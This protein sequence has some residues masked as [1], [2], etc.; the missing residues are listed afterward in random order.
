MVKRKTYAGHCVVCVFALL[1]TPSASW[2]LLPVCPLLSRAVHRPE[3]FRGYEIHQQTPCF[4]HRSS[5]GRWINACHLRATTRDSDAGLTDDKDCLGD[6]INTQDRTQE[7]SFLEWAGLR[8]ISAP[9]VQI[10]EFPAG[11]RGMAATTPIAAGEALV[12]LP[13][14]ICLSVGN[15]QPCPFPNFVSAAFW[16][17]QSLH[18]RLALVL[19][20]EKYQRLSVATFRASLILTNLLS[21]FALPRPQSFLHVRWNTSD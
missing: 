18:V 16:N 8:G 5:S 13:R 11:Y 10:S 7:D 1:A 9:S 4:G 3:F 17:T 21:S 12:S 6:G 14:S 15:R 19:M 2:V 20:W